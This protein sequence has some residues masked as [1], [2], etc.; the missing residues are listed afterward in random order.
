MASGLTAEEMVAPWEE[1]I[2]YEFETRNTE[3]T[4]ETMVEDA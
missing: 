2:K 3:D 1:H 4:L